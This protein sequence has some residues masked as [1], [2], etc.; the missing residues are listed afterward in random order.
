MDL[1]PVKKVETSMVAP[2]G[3]Y[4]SVD[5]TRIF[6][7]VIAQNQPSK[8]TLHPSPSTKK[9]RRKKEPRYLKP[10]RNYTYNSISPSL[11]IHQDH[12]I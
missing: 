11:N 4:Y 7:V 10:S 8:E 9:E 12:N 2:D 5:P 1:K 3:L 6:V